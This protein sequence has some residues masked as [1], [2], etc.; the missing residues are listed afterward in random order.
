MVGGIPSFTPAA[1]GLPHLMQH[2]WEMYSE[3]LEEVIADMKKRGQTPAPIKTALAKA[4]ATHFIDFAEAYLN[5]HRVVETFFVDANIGL[6]LNNQVTVALA[7]LVESVGGT[8][9]DS[10]VV[11]VLGERQQQDLRGV[12][13][14][15]GTVIK[16]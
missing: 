10:L 8:M 3:H 9:Q 16:M 4:P 12:D 15:G 5:A 1:G 11:P 2:L 6:R 14:V 7:P 13:S